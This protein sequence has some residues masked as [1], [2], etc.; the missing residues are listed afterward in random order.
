MAGR[1]QRIGYQRVRTGDH[2]ELRRLEGQ[3]LERVFADN[4]SG[5][6]TARPQLIEPALHPR[7]R[8]FR[9]AQHG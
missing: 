3:L 8:D 1:D 7:R 5:R 4:A 9:S 6:D 2:N